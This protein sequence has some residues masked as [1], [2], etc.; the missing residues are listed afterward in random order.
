M[1]IKVKD[2]GMTTDE[3]QVKQY[4]MTNRQGMRAVLLN[5][6]AVITEL[7]VPGQEGRASRCGLGL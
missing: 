6:G 3:Q 7:H 1:S 5:Y 2:Y 4:I